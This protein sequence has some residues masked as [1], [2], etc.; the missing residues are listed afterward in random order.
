MGSSGSGNSPE[1]APLP[2][3]LPR[4]VLATPTLMVSPGN[5]F[6]E[7]PCTGVSPPALLLWLQTKAQW[8]SSGPRR[9][10]LRLG[11]WSQ[12]TSRQLWV[13]CRGSQWP[14]FRSIAV[15][16]SQEEGDARNRAVFLVMEGRRET[17]KMHSSGGSFT[18]LGPKAAFVQT[19]VSCGQKSRAG[20]FGEKQDFRAA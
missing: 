19:L 8:S 11:L 9:P 2:Q 16:R 12:V 18:S 13:Q 10:A 4:P 3:L 7:V 17:E 1:T 5:S 6:L 15:L 20:A 14:S